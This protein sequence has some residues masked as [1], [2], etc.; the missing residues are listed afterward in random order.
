MPELAEVEYMRQRWDPGTG[1]TVRTVRMHRNA[2]VF[3][4]LNPRHLSTLLRGSRL[5]FSEARGKQM[6]FH[7]GPDRWL[8]IHLGMTGQLEVKSWSHRPARHEHL[9]LQMDTVSLVFRD[10]RLF[11]RIRFETGELPP[12]WWTSL[13]PDLHGPDFGRRDLDC[14]L[15]RRAK[16]SIKA[17]LLMQERFPGIGNWMA[18][19]I[20]WRC[21]V[22][23]AR[24]AGSLAPDERRRLYREIRAVVRASLKHIARPGDHWGDPPPNWLFHQRWA[25][26]GLCPKARSPLTREKIGGRTTCWSPGWQS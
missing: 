5:Q 16:S 12:V 25:D 9:V 13:P 17:V 18:D 8:G 15:D 3:R 11:G 22:R 7:F 4:G 26:G 6:I 14:F 23:P 1:S 24:R 10:T 21:R 2:K 19:E 20:L